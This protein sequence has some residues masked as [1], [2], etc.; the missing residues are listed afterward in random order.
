MKIDVNVLVKFLSKVKM[1]TS[2][3]VNDCILDFRA[4]GLYI[5]ADSPTK[6]VK[7]I[8]ELKSS[9][10]SDYE[11]IGKGCVN[12]FGNIVNVFGR[13][14]GDVNIAK[15]A[16]LLKLSG[17]NKKVNVELVSENY[18]EKSGVLP[19]LDYENKFSIEMASLKSIYKDVGMSKDATITIAT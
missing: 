18:I 2:Q 12:D 15:S 9:A 17:G 13:F 6:Q 11:D 14:E 8:G 5:D 4:S 7:V 10:F 3:A 16:N 1:N 19:K